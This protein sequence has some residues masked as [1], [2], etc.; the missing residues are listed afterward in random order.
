GTTPEAHTPPDDLEGVRTPEAE[1]PLDAPEGVL[2]PEAEPPQDAPEGVPA[3]PARRPRQRRGAWQEL[4]EETLEAVPASV[5]DFRGWLKTWMARNGFPKAYL[6]KVQVADSTGSA[7]ASCR[8]KDEAKARHADRVKHLPP[9]RALVQLLSEH[10]PEEE[11]PDEA[12]LAKA[13]RRCIKGTGSKREIDTTSGDVVQAWL[14]F[15][16][17]QF[18][19]REAKSG[20]QLKYWAAELRDDDGFLPFRVPSCSRRRQTRRTCPPVLLCDVTY[21]ISNSGWGLALFA[22]ASQHLDAHTAWP[23]SQAIIIGAAWVPKAVKCL[24]PD[25]LLARDV[26]HVQANVKK[27]SSPSSSTPLALR[28]YLASRVLFSAALPTQTLF[29]LLWDE[30]LNSLCGRPEMQTYPSQHFAATPRHE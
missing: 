14:D 18:S 22:L 12:E 11:M 24:L 25:A 30:V 10:V 15:L 6:S 28:D 20:H 21:K 1:P 3:E 8:C 29:T 26:R 23:A 27:H 13:H 17:V 5:D 9:L 19:L 4:A 7:F 16:A 2:I